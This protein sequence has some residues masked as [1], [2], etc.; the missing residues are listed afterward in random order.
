MGNPLELR[1]YWPG[2]PAGTELHEKV[3][4]ERIFNPLTQNTKLEETG[5]R[6]Q[7]LNQ[8][9]R[10]LLEALRDVVNRG[11]DPSQYEIL[12][13]LD[14]G[15]L[16]DKMSVRDSTLALLAGNKKGVYTD[17]LTW[18]K[19]LD[20][21][22]QIN[23][24]GVLTPDEYNRA[25][26]AKLL[27][28]DDYRSGKP[29]SVRQRARDIKNLLDEIQARTNLIGQDVPVN[30]ELI[31]VGKEDI[32][33][34]SGYG[35]LGRGEK[36]DKN[37]NRIGS[38]PSISRAALKQ[39]INEKAK[40][41]AAGLK[42][43]ELGLKGYKGV[44]LNDLGGAERLRLV[45]A[46]EE[47]RK[48]AQATIQKYKDLGVD[49]K[50]Y[51]GMEEYRKAV[52]ML[53]NP[54]KYALPELGYGDQSSAPSVTDSGAQ[55]ASLSAPSDATVVRPGDPP[56]L[57]GKVGLTLASAAGTGTLPPPHSTL[58]IGQGPSS[59]S[60]PTSYSG[61]QNEIDIERKLQENKRLGLP[62]PEERIQA[63]DRA[64][65][66]EDWERGALVRQ[67]ERDMV[68]MRAEHAARLK[69]TAM[70]NDA[71]M[72]RYR[73]ELEYDRQK[74]DEDRRIKLAT[75]GYGAAADLLSSIFM[76][77]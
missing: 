19:L 26:D 59:Q 5:T 28:K 44:N 39:R 58:P 29:K 16:K 45:K 63:R 52:D 13:Q 4:L 2:T 30:G 70:Q 72:E 24:S 31:S 66:Q 48:E 55:L 76:Y 47:K 23:T 12:T 36:L 60:G 15:G 71:N 20:R 75:I 65:K 43:E 25:K 38:T 33:V 74:D 7:P 69:E 34:T 35:L 57:S 54:E 77:V 8:E 27:Y 41:I 42:E 11:A 32:G 1:K 61:L 18:E 22:E 50:R 53:K 3:L 14:R 68:K 37:G 51:T 46:V 67:F 6:G 62:S 21:A 40:L 64:R 73:A 49:P 10:E 56:P 9:G 17:G